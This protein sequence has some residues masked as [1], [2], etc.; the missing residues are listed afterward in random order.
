M[1][2]SVIRNPGFLGVLGQWT[3]MTVHYL[4]NA[5]ANSWHLIKE[6][7]YDITL[8]FNVNFCKRL[9]KFSRQLHSFHVLVSWLGI[10]FGGGNSD[11]FS[12]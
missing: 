1:N 8:E 11:R 6:G 4:V 5:H 10:E 12:A 7:Q 3:E 2:G 9:E